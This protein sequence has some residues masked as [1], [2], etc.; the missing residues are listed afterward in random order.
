MS[1]VNDVRR[2]GPVKTFCSLNKDGMHTWRLAIRFQAFSKW[3]WRRRRSGVMWLNLEAEPSSRVHPWLD[4]SRDRRCDGMPVPVQ[5]YSNPAGRWQATTLYNDWSGGEICMVAWTL[6]N[7]C[8]AVVVVAFRK[9]RRHN[10]R[11]ASH[12]GLYSEVYKE[13]GWRS[14]IR[15]D[16]KR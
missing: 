4:W 8:S 3:S 6:T 14:L 2:C 13:R 15:A 1:F 12:I 16:P 9:T 7:G 10:F 5:R 11:H